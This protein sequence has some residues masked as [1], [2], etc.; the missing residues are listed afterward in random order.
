MITFETFIIGVTI[1]SAFAG[2][3][4]EAVKKILKEFNAKYHANTL[5]G[6][7]TSVLAA[8]LGTSYVILSGLAFTLSTVTCIAGLA[9]VSWLVSMV[10]YDKVMQT[11]NQFKNDGK[12]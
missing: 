7:V 2:L 4:T 11:I 9:F 10:G 6:I 1:V 8:G 3:V 5:A 12:D